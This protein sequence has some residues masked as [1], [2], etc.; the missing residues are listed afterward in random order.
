M[1]YLIGKDVTS[2]P[3]HSAS[4]WVINFHDFDIATA[5]SYPECFA[6]VNERVKPYRDQLRGQ[7]HE[8]AYWRFQDK[9]LDS[10]AAI[11]QLETVL[12]VAMTSKL[13]SPVFVPRR[14]LFDQQ[15]VVFKSNR[16]D[17]F[18]VLSSSL[19]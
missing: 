6:I 7:I 3:E 11:N 1:P 14:Q 19:H 16:I 4:R 12:V 8:Q 18:S 15:L 10:Y 2:H 13:L 9:R 17:L 5:K